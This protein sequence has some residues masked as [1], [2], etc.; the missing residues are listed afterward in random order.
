MHPFESSTPG[1]SP[2]DTHD[3]SH[4]PAGSGLADP[5]LPSA[6]RLPQPFGPGPSQSVLRQKRA[7]KDKHAHDFA[8]VKSRR[9][10]EQ[11]H[12][13]PLKL[14]E[15]GS[16]SQARTRSQTSGGTSGATASQ[17]KPPGARAAAKQRPP[18][19][20]AAA[21]QR[22]PPRAAAEQR[23]PPPR[24]PAEQR[25][26]PTPHNPP[27]TTGV[28]M[29]HETSPREDAAP[30]QSNRVPVGRQPSFRVNA[31]PAGPHKAQVIRREPSFQVRPQSPV[32]PHSETT[33]DMQGR[34][35][36]TREAFH[37]PPETFTLAES[38]WQALRREQEARDA[39]QEEERL[40]EKLRQEEELQRKRRREQDLWLQEQSRT[41]S[42]RLEEMRREA[43]RREDLRREELRQ[44]ALQ[45]ELRQENLRHEELRQENLRH[46]ELRQENLRREE[47]R[48]ENLRQEA[49]WRQ[50]AL[51]QEEQAHPAQ[52]RQEGS[53]QETLCQEGSYHGGDDQTDEE[54]LEEEVILQHL[55]EDDDQPYAMDIDADMPSS[56]P[57][58][59]SFV[60]YTPTIPRD[61]PRSTT[62]VQ[63]APEDVRSPPLGSDDESPDF[64]FG[65]FP[66]P[67]VFTSDLPQQSSLPPKPPSSPTRPAPQ[68][69]RPPPPEPTSRA[70]PS[71]VPPNTH[72]YRVPSPTFHP[73]TSPLPMKASQIDNVSSQF[74]SL[75]LQQSEK[76]TLI[77]QTLVV[78]NRELRS[79]LTDQ[80][81]AVTERLDHLETSGFPRA[82]HTADRKPNIND[83][84]ELEGDEGVAVN[85]ASDGDDELDKEKPKVRQRR[86]KAPQTTVFSDPQYGD[87]VK[88]LQKCIRMHLFNLCDVTTID[89]LVE[90]NPPISDDEMKSFLAGDDDELT[91]S[92]QHFRVDFVRSWKENKFNQLAKSIFVKSFIS[93]YKG[94]EYPDCTIPGKLLTEL[95]VGIALDK[96]MDYRRKNYRRHLKPLSKED[97]DLLKKRKAMSSRR[98]TIRDSRVTVILEYKLTQHNRLFC[99]LRP[100]HMSGDETDGDEKTHPPTFCIVEARWQSLAFKLFL[101]M[102][103]AL[104]RELWAQPIGDRATPGNPPRIRVE[105]ADPRVE[106]GVAPIGLWRN[107]YDSDWLKSLR[108]HVRESLNIID[109]DYD[110]TL[111]KLKPTKKQA[112]GKA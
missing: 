20:R 94:G 4:V 25:P 48:Q 99:I 44:A 58:P 87:G 49:L 85:G 12:A 76:M 110:F 86:R 105:R 62:P 67:D 2:S 56:Q 17:L 60:P 41:E 15:K 33:P 100:I 3:A 95:V 38:R 69:H 8:G 9:V 14:A 45:E 80:F 21:D 40:R 23:A 18:P 47:Q 13:P 74:M 98:G 24:G 101:R 90:K 39:F 22:P 11:T 83:Q 6:P 35:E 68:T 84:D 106:D 54:E 29:G 43:L 57:P 64:S 107:C 28:P 53:R 75:L 89:E 51:R 36:A 30:S 73:A 93:M 111:P 72:G 1:E 81:S 26:L 78:E 70:H 88:D 103:D 91:C 97:K 102:L 50:E 61:A 31:Q 108:P 112:N 96:H 65:A 10:D 66:S 34:R 63:P 27:Q 77:M 55:D 19:P 7:L 92:L 32:R 52:L 46:E 109:K 37:V 42:L 82:A 71:T 79:V 5:P 104:Y 16:V 59:P